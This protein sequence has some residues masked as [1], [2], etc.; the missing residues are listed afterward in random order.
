MTS[1]DRWCDRHPIFTRF[2]VPAIVT[3]SLV[4][5]VWEVLRR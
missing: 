5:Q 3:A 1:H 2:Y 4:V